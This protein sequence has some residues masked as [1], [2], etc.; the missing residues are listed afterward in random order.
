MTEEDEISIVENIKKDDDI[1][2]AYLHFVENYMYNLIL[3]Y[4]YL[5]PISGTITALINFKIKSRK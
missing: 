1:S 5:N 3:Q 4:S 2:F